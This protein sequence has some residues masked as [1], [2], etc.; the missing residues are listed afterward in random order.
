MIFSTIDRSLEIEIVERE[1]KYFMSLSGTI[2]PFYSINK[3]EVVS[4]ALCM[5][6]AINQALKKAEK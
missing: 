5:Q 1:G 2:C 6:W 4:H 3:S